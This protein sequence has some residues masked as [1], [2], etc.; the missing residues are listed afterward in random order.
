MGDAPRRLGLCLF[1]RSPKEQRFPAPFT[2]FFAP[3][4]PRTPTAQNDGLK[5]GRSKKEHRSVTSTLPPQFRHPDF[6]ERSI[7][8]LVRSKHRNVPFMFNTRKDLRERRHT[9]LASTTRSA[10]RDTPRRLGVCLFLRSPKDQRFVAPFT[11]FFAP[12]CT[13][14]PTAQND[15]LKGGT[16]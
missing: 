1:L 11:R 9:R 8:W 6:T 14:T 15:G 3:S 2:R 16:E 13:R 10:M 4:C 7:S 12:S 5:G